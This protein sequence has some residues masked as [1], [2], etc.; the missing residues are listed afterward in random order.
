M[1]GAPWG[2][3]LVKPFLIVLAVGIFVG[4]VLFYIG[5]KII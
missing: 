1:S 3:L 4:A 2:N 5:G